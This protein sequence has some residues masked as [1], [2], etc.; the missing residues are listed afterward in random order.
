MET[1]AIALRLV[2]M[3]VKAAVLCELATTKV[4]FEFGFGFR[5][6]HGQ[7]VRTENSGLNK[8]EAKS[9]HLILVVDMIPSPKVQSFTFLFSP[10]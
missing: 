10:E 4:A 5:F 9:T 8:S 3:L 1:A 2:I 6:S 7:C